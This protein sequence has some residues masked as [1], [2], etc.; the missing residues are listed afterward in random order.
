VWVDTRFVSDE[1][2][3]RF[4][5]LASKSFA[6]GVDDRV[7]ESLYVMSHLAAHA[8]ETIGRNRFPLELPVA[9]IF[10]LTMRLL[11]LLYV[12]KESEMENDV[13]VFCFVSFLSHSYP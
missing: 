3:W 8:C 12:T 1:S 13:S 5:L 6:R 9:D 4:F 10:W 11:R 7:M 2:L